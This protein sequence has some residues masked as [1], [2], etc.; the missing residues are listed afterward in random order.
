MERR[1][2]NR[3]RERERRGEGE[4]HT[5]LGS[6]SS[7]RIAS[8]LTN[9]TLWANRHVEMVSC[10]INAHTGCMYTVFPLTSMYFFSTEHVAIIVVMQFPP[11]LNKCIC[12]SEY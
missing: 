4:N 3:E 11:R 2:R 12:M 10:E 6:S 7:L 9:A 5:S 1:E 8:F